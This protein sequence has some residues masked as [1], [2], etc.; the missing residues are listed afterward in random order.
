[1]VVKIAKYVTTYSVFEKEIQNHPGESVQ[2]PMTVDQ[3]E[4]FEILELRNGKVRG[5]DSL[6]T[7][8]SGN[9]NPDM[10]SLNHANV[11]CTVADRHCNNAEMFLRNGK[12]FS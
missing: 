5:H 1:M 4:S 2:V 7:F 9:T 6:S 8:H 10:S 12:K 3:N 11:I